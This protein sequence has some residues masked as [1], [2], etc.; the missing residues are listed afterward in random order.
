MME[1]SCRFVLS[2]RSGGDERF[3]TLFLI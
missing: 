1:N 3:G 2:A